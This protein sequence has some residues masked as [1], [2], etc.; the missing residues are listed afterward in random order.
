[1][2]LINE[3]TGETIRDG[4]TPA[5]VRALYDRGV[6]SLLGEDAETGGSGSGGEQLPTDREP[7]EDADPSGGD[8]ADGEPTDDDHDAD[9][10]AGDAGDG[11]EQDD[12]LADVDPDELADAIEEMERQARER[13][14]GDWYGVSD[15]YREA[16][17]ED[18]RRYERLQKRIEENRTPLA[19]RQADRDQRIR[20][21]PAVWSGDEVRAELRETGLAQEV[22]DA[23]RRLKTQDHPEP[24]DDGD[25]LH[26]EGYIRHLAGDYSEDEFYLESAAVEAG[27]RAV[28]VALDMSGSMNELDAKVALGALWVATN[29]IG[30]DL[31]ASAYY[32]SNPRNEPRTTLITGPGE[33]F[34]WDHLDAVKTRDLTP[35]PSGIADAKGLLAGTSKR[36]EVLIVI[37]DGEANI[38]T[39]GRNDTNDALR[40][41]A[42]YVNQARAEGIKVI[43]LGV[44]PVVPEMMAATFGDDG[45][46]MA[47]SEDMADAL[48]EVYRRQM[49]VEA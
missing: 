30:D 16:D 2:K 39:D 34:D 31:V 4:L 23:F 12:P 40:E 38:T 21:N 6:R 37:T 3:Q 41:T 11:D 43:G 9:P 8:A 44:E 25:E 49:K 5:D 33:S 46:V 32:T 35:T 13:E 18:V 15:D 10:D 14:S 27:D 26:I 45:Y 19:Q 17:A 7:P 47:R 1:M 42:E 29:A 24:A 36:E 28:A 48:V 22:E 20:E